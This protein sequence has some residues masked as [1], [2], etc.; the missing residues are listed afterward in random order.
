MI[1]GESDTA[2]CRW[3]FGH[4]YASD[5]CGKARPLNRCPLAFLVTMQTR[6]ENILYYTTFY[7]SGCGKD[8]HCLGSCHRCCTVAKLCWVYLISI[9]ILMRVVHPFPSCRWNSIPG[10]HYQLN[11]AF[12]K[13]FWLAN[14]VQDAAY[15]LQFVDSEVRPLNGRYTYTMTFKKPPPTNGAFWSVQVGGWVRFKGFGLTFEALGSR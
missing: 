9:V 7:L 12:F 11:A 5:T 8:C 15:I 3:P 13:G 1:A 2:R 10:S 14:I 4:H 6:R